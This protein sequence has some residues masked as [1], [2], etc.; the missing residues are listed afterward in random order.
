MRK[1]LEASEQKVSQLEKEKVELIQ[2]K[3]A[4]SVDDKKSLDKAA[5][6]LL[7][8]RTK[9]HKAEANTEELKVT[10]ISLEP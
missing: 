1:Q 8:L 4:P 7:Q 6:E 2:R 5:S 10:R 9:L 3:S